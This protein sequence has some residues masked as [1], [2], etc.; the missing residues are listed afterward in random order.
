[1]SVIWRKVWR[2]LWGNKLRT[3]LVVLATTTGVFAIG[4]VFG[5][6]SVMLDRLDEDFEASTPPHLTFRT[7]L[8]DKS[9]VDAIRREPGVIA[10]E[11]EIRADF[12]WKLEGEVDWRPGT[13]ISRDDYETQYMYLIDLL[14]GHWP[15]KRTLAVERLSSDYFDLPMGATVLVEVGQ[16]EYSLPIEGL[17]RHPHTPPPQLGEGDAT[18]CVT[19]ETLA[20]LTNQEQGFNTL[21]VR[22]ES[23]SYEAAQEAGARIDDRLESVG[24]KARSNEGAGSGEGGAHGESASGTASTWS[25]ID[26]DA[27]WGEE[28]INTVTLILAVLGVL[29]LALSGFLIINTMNATIV[30]EIWQIGV[31]KVI[32]ASAGRVARIY[33]AMALVYSL[34][35]LFV[36][37]PLGAAVANY[38]AVW[39]LDLFNVILADF[40]FMPEAVAIQ[41]AMGLV[42]PLL[43]AVVAVSG[44]ARITVREAISS[45]GMGGKFGRGWFDRLIGQIRS[46]P[47]PLALSLRNT[48]RRKARVALTL[49]ALAGGGVMFVM[50]MSVSTSFDNTLNAL[51]SDFG[52]DTTIV[53]D[54]PYS[55][56]RLIEASE[57]V[58]GVSRAEVWNRNGAQLVLPNGEDLPVGLWGVPSDS[59]MFSPRIVSGRNLL[60]GEGNAILLNNKIATD[61]GFQVGD[62]IE[63]VIGGRKATWT[64]VGLIVNISNGSQDNFAP[65]DALARAT[66]GADRGGQVL[67][68]FD[69]PSP[70]VQQK[71]TDDLRDVYEARRIKTSRVE[72]A[73]QIREREMSSFNVISILMLTM[74]ILAA[75]VG[76]AGLMSTMSINVVER[77]REIGMMRAIGATSPSIIRIFVIESVLVGLLS[78][79]VAV[80]LSYPGAHAFSSVVGAEVINL[81]LDFA[82]PVYSLILWLAVIVVIS[83]VAS[84]WPA[85]QATK[86]SVREALAYE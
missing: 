7:G 2:D 21:N 26:P 79:L 65:F 52:F 46:L 38:M 17:V 66:G 25:I 56:A 57:S 86:V 1:M 20:W 43:A 44:G 34:L 59:Q 45:H 84:L 31:M 85:L 82:Y 60:P 83:A 50:T 24:L 40:R 61:E 42:V 8:F 13:L 75:V 47:R 70:G 32:G 68:T 48:F 9:L 11:G 80:P 67:V 58:P 54:R 63:L 49:L 29:S 33:L 53:L 72:A 5:L 3:L 73:S 28:M 69:D 22:L 16:R 10:A 74:A 62:E 78:W 76:S 36:A 35:S 37:V 12:R 27:H 30:Q 64:V 55:T 18:F 39:L 77:A 4:M 15:T 14:D 51:L 6:S 19:L 41:V 23:L 71:L 81:P